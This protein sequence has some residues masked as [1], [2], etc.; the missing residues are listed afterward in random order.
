MK[1]QTLQI[2]GALL[3]TTALSTLSTMSMAGNFENAVNAGATSALTTFTP[4]NLSAQVFGG[5]A[6]ENITLGPTQF[7]IDF[8]NTL[9]TSFNVD[10]EPTG[11]KFDTDS[12]APVLVPLAQSAG[13]TLSI[14]SVVASAC[15]LQVLTERILISNCVSVDTPTGSKIDHIQLSGVVFDQANGLATAGQS[16]SLSGIVTGSAGNQTFELLS[17]GTIVTS[18]DSVAISS[19][20]G[21]FT[22]SNTA[23]PPFSNLG[24]ATTARL[25]SVLASVVENV[26]T[27][28]STNISIASSLV[29]SMEF[30]VTHGVLT[31]AAVTKLELSA[32]N[33]TNVSLT[34]SAFVSNTASFDLN[35]TGTFGTFAIDVDFDGTTAIQAWPAGTLTVALSAGT[36]AVTAP[37]GLTDVALASFTRGGFSAQINT[38]QSSAVSGFD[39]FVRITNNGAVNGTATIEVRNDST[40]SLYGSFTTGTIEPNATIQVD[41][42][43]IEAGIPI[44]TPAGQ[45]MLNLSGSISGYAQHVM[46]N[47]ATGSFVDLSGFRIGDATTGFP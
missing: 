39:S 12:T 35:P 20:A 8:T 29:G 18:R 23:S 11:A 25:G 6:P 10:I 7:N 4:I 27:D 2:S 24:T 15:T 47:T 31:D 21:S 22:L 46:L 17:S 26:A 36:S 28:L 33:G 43:S 1:R 9:T 42:P 13:T 16:I 14:A 5:T 45:Y 40:G 37:T 32:T 34:P 38:A 19:S 3:A 30:A 41:M 44:A